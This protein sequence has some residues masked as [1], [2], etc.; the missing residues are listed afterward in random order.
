MQAIKTLKEEGKIE[1]YNFNKDAVI[2]HDLKGDSDKNV[3]EYSGVYRIRGNGDFETVKE[4]PDKK[5]ITTLEDA[6]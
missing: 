1:V 2:N 3:C 4:F 6:L 5:Y